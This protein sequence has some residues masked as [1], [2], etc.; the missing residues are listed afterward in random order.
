MSDINSVENTRSIA[1]EA[2]NRSAKPAVEQA[3][4]GRDGGKTLPVQEKQA[5]PPPQNS[6]PESQRRSARVEQAVEQLNE[7]VQ[8]LQRDLQFSL[9]EELGRA[10]I[11]VIDSSTQEVIRQIPNETALQLARNLKADLETEQIDRAAQE[12]RGQ[13]ADTVAQ[14][15][16]GVE[17]RLG[18]INTRV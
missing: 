5:A 8:S 6:Q 13:S 1:V 2:R 3:T 7:Y 17:A 18:L 14:G 10:V 9:D 12:L 4:S 16:A 11:R 15:T